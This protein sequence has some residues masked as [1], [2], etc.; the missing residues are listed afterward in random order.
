MDKYI[1]YLFVDIVVVIVSFFVYVLFFDYD[2]DEDIFFIIVEEE[3]KMVFWEIFV[4]LVG[5]KWEWFLFGSC[6][7]EV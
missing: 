5:L 3:V 4:N 7:L 1:N 2:D 6:F